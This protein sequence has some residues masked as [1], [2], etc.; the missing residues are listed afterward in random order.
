VRRQTAIVGIGQAGLS[1]A[2]EGEPWDL[3]IAAVNAA[4]E[5]AGI[6]RSEVD[7][8]IRYISPFETVTQPMM[9][10]ALGLDEVRYLCDLPMGG[11]ASAAS[12]VHGAAAILSGQANVVV[13]Y[14]S[15]KQSGGVRYGRAFGGGSTTD[16]AGNTLISDQDNRA[17]VW[18]YGVI[19]PAQIFALWATRYM[20]EAG[21]TFEQFSEALGTISITQRAYSHSNPHAIMGQRPMTREDYDNARMISWPLRLFDMCLENDGACAVVLV[22]AERA[23]TL[24]G[25]PAYVLAATQSLTPYGEPMGQLYAQ[26]YMR[27]AHPAAIE[28]LYRTAGVG[29]GDIS[30]AAFYDASNFFTLRTLELYGFAERWKAAPYLAEHGIGLDSPLPVNTHGG[31]LS[32]GYIHGMTGILEA[33]RQLRGSAYN[34][35]KDVK[36]SLYATITGHAVVFGR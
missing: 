24:G 6:D 7:G 4:L 14:R 27:I 23:R 5:D 11:E 15:I 3:A 19:A 36:H 22:S 33:V 2:A 16:E 13:V 30:V 8:L 12:I 28:R 29:P 34:Q 26:E 21:L 31:H 32:E 18:P 35:V 20:H 25:Q 1:K 10:A 9:T 17:Y